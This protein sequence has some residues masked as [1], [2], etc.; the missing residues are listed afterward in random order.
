MFVY[1]VIRLWS[2]RVKLQAHRIPAPAP[3]ATHTYTHNCGIKEH[4]RVYEHWDL[5]LGN[6]V[7]WHLP[8]YPLEFIMCPQCL[9]DQPFFPVS[10]VTSLISAL[11]ISHL[12][13]KNSLVSC[14][15]GSNLPQFQLTSLTDGLRLQDIAVIRWHFS[16]TSAKDL[17]H[18][19]PKR[20]C[21]P[22][23]ILPGPW[24]G[25]PSKN[26]WSLESSGKIF[27][28]RFMAAFYWWD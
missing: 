13:Y 14:L 7:F 1:V 5:I 10:T 17:H 4:T 18:L 22:C 15:S 9:S 28:C 23:I 11:V 6:L 25:R 16:S 20:S 21:C 26:V 24:W 12:Y 27:K 8:I 2:F 3:P 19:S